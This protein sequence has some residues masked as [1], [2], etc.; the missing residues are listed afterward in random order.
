MDVGAFPL[1]DSP[2][3][4]ARLGR[5]APNPCKVRFVISRF[6]YIVEKYYQ[7]SIKIDVVCR[8]ERWTESERNG[9]THI[10]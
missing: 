3:A 10:H 7:G 2:Q 9:D 1:Q 8:I 4:S 6:V 5:K